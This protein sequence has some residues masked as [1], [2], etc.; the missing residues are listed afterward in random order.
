MLLDCELLLLRVLL[1]LPNL[2]P[3]SE[4]PAS[5]ALPASD[6][7][8]ELLYTSS[9]EMPPLASRFFREKRLVVGDRGFLIVV[10]GRPVVLVIFKGVPDIENGMCEAPAVKAATG[11]ADLD[12]DRDVPRVSDMVRP[13]GPSLVAE[14]ERGSA[15]VDAKGEAVVGASHGELE[16]DAFE[17][18]EAPGLGIGMFV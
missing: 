18:A 3:M 10:L 7:D 14:G 16:V 6:F 5:E 4:P 13:S 1:K 15:E 17:L 9:D 11:P 2:E 8:D 12:G